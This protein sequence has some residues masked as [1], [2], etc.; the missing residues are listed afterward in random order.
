MCPKSEKAQNRGMCGLF[1]GFVRVWWLFY[2]CVST[3]K[4]Q[5]LEFVIEKINGDDILVRAKVLRD[6]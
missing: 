3:L 2:G 1:Y 5:Y 4:S 6:F